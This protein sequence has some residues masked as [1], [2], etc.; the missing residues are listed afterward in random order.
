MKHF[1][2]YGG[3]A[4]THTG[5]ARANRPLSQ[6][7]QAD[8]RPFQA[9]IEAGGQGIL[10]SHNIVECLDPQRPASISPAV[11]QYLRKE[12]GFTG[13]A[14]TDDLAMGA[15]KEGQEEHPAVQALRAGADFLIVSE[16]PSAASAVGQAIEQG[17]LSQA[18]VDQAAL[19]VLEWKLALGILE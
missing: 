7:E 8:L 2:G 15:M 13:V 18:R 12:M 9:G 11:Y 17:T 6:F 5:S 4:D 16:L 3:N 10:V 19:R 1:P 14:L